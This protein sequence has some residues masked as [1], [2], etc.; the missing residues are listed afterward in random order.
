SGNPFGRSESGLSS[1]V[2]PS[3]TIT[4]EPKWFPRGPFP[5]KVALG[6]RSEVATHSAGVNPASPVAPLGL[7]PPPCGEG[8]K[9]VPSGLL[10]RCLC[11]WSDAARGKRE[12]FG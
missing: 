5:R 11:L 1:D 3:T 8:W 7:V 2:F 4:E 9:G 12:A 6:S 10:A